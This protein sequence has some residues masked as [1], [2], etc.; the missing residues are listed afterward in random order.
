MDLANL[1]NDVTSPKKLCW[2]ISGS[3]YKS[4]VFS[5]T[6]NLCHTTQSSPAFRVAHLTQEFLASP[7]DSATPHKAVQ[8]F[9]WRTSRRRL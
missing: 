5:I 2:K 8:R 9:E 7:P 1:T 3:L 4:G 6:P